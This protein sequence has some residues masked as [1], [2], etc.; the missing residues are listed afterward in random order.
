MTRPRTVALAMHAGYRC[1]HVGACCSAG[2]RVPVERAPAGRIRDAVARGV[3]NRP[4]GSEALDPLPVRRGLPAEYGGELAHRADG[5]CLFFDHDGR[6]LCEVHRVLGEAALGQA[7]RQFPRMASHDARGTEI[8]LSHFCPTAAAR[9][10]GDG[11]ATW[12]DA[13]SSFPQAGALE[14]MDA[15]DAL[16]PLLRPG[17][18]CSFGGWTAWQQYVLETLAASG[19]TPSAFNALCETAERLRAWDAERGEFDAFVAAALETPLGARRDLEPGA[20]A[21][22]GRREVEMA[23][24]VAIDAVPSAFAPPLPPD[25][26]RWPESV[27]DWRDH[28]RILRRYVAARSVGAWVAYQGRGLR[29]WVRWLALAWHVALAERCRAPDAANPTGS[30]PLEAIRRADLL[31]VH[32]VDPQCLADALSALEPQPLA[33][34]LLPFDGSG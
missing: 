22:P 7:C 13:S 24:A 28:D 27:D 29:T 5:A 30:A 2:W 8:S 10:A 18:L 26:A 1:R 19:S 34:R 32:L 33:A 20:V 17:V 25:W 9:L 14:G 4:P 3:L 16:P 23:W 21:W 15:H 11:E 12:V 6:R 31:L